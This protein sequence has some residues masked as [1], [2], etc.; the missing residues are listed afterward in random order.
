[1]LKKHNSLESYLKEKE[2]LSTSSHSIRDRD[3]LALPSIITTYI[4]ST[5]PSKFIKLI[6][7]LIIL[8]NKLI[9]MKTKDK[10]QQ[11]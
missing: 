4:S 3:L 1:M 6:K 5:P 10:L 9:Q 2:V 7:L 11:I 8:Y